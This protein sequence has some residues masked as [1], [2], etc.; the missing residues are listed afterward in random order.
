MAGE[1]P[2]LGGGTWAAI[3]TS[4]GVGGAAIYKS[5]RKVKEDLGDDATAKKA[6]KAMDGILNR[7]EAEISRQNG[8]IISL[9]ERIDKVEKERNDAIAMAAKAQAEVLVQAGKVEAL[10]ADMAD[11]KAELEAAEKKIEMADTGARRRAT[12]P[13]DDRDRNELK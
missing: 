13:I 12:D 5:I 3:L 10:E 9:T 6:D 2:D 8:V 1:L 4:L 11:L 7:L